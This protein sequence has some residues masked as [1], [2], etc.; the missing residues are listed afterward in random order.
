[1]IHVEIDPNSG[2]CFGVVRAI[3]KAEDYLKQGKKISSLGEMVHNAAEVKRLESMGMHTISCNDLDENQNENILIRAHGEPPSTYELLKRRGRNIVDATCPI[4]LKLQQKV[5]KTY[6]SHPEAQI[7][8]YG[9]EGHAEVIGLAGQTQQEAIILTVPEDI[10]KLDPKKP[11]FMFSQT[12]MPLDGFAAIK[13]A[14]ENYIQADVVSYDTICRKVAHRI[15]EVRRFAAMHDVCVFVSGKNSSNGQ[16]LYNAAKTAN[17]NTYFVTKASEINQDW[18]KNEI[19][20]GICGA[21]STPQW[22]MK[23]A[24]TTI[25][26]WF[27][28][29]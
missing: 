27:N 18:F 13:K 22:Q 8:I 15:P 6:E 19:S 5:K 7:V 2:F 11:V 24:K 12:T 1:M 26:S 16:M 29:N 9:K 3:E 14:L 28:Q 21:T 17:P 23:E 10:K 20:V 25:E 4:V